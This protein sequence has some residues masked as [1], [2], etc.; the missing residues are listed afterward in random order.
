MSFNF[1]RFPLS[2]GS[3][4][5][6]QECVPGLINFAFLGLSTLAFNTLKL[7]LS[8][9]GKFWPEFIMCVIYFYPHAMSPTFYNILRF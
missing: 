1:F 9:G 7:L 3:D 5:V 6:P 2:C 8:L 4:T